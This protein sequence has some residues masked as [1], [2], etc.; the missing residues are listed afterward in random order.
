MYPKSPFLRNSLVESQILRRNANQ[1]EELMNWLCRPPTITTYRVNTLRISV[2]AFKQKFQQ[3]LFEKY[4][5]PPKVYEIPNIPEVVCIP[6]TPLSLLD[7][8]KKET[9]PLREVVVDG[10]CGAA[11]LRGAHIYAPGVLAMEAGTKLGE[12]VLVYAD[13]AGKCKQGTNTRYESDEKLFL[14]VG[15]VRMQRHQIYGPAAVDKAEP[16]KG[17]AV[18]MIAT[19]SGVPSIGD[20]SSNEALLQ[21]LPSIVCVRVLNPQPGER[22]LDMCAAPGN[23][24]MHM[25]EMMGDQGEI[26]ALDKVVNKITT[27]QEKITANSLKS[28]RSYA[29]DASRVYDAAKVPEDNACLEMPPYAANTFDK[30]LLDAPC[31]ALGNRPLLTV[32]PHMSARML[33]SYPKVQR[34]L[35]T[36]AVPLL[37]PNGVLVYSTC[38]VTEQENEGIVAW[39]LEKFPQMKLV[40]ATPRLGGSGLA[41]NGLSDV[42]RQY[43]QR[44]SHDT[45]EA[46][47]VP[48]DAVGFFIAKFIKKY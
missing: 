14:G 33:D 37:K 41:Y 16:S 25:V 39:V 22:V 34:K 44:F 7:L 3:I 11:L 18:E 4:A 5:K 43:L 1:L 6:P 10:C 40:A 24:T 32:S 42:E 48:I 8:T 12:E 45:T 21:N 17:V 29:F 46:E 36:A 31:S 20:L 47:G 23:K 30:I 19:T 2:P 27:L 38:T 28:V 35:F 26:I 15:V 9:E 13:L